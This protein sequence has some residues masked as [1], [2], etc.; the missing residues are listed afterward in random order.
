[1]YWPPG[2]A[3]SAMFP[4]PWRPGPRGEIGRHSDLKSR[5]L[6]ACGFETRRGHAIPDRRSR[7]SSSGSPRC[8]PTQSPGKG[9]AGQFLMCPASEVLRECVTTPLLFT[10]IV[11]PLV[12]ATTT[13]VSAWAACSAISA[14]WNCFCK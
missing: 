7:L 4:Q 10:I 8:T 1:M 13:A 5:R 2:P 9:C 11:G 6:R 14:A 3:G 12:E